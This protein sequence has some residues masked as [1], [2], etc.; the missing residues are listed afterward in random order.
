MP[1]PIW[2]IHFFSRFKYYNAIYIE[3]YVYTA[4]DRVEIFYPNARNNMYM[5]S[6]CA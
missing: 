2:F 5:C 3:F 6:M 4:F 1:L